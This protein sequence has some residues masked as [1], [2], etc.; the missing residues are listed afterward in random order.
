[1]K[2]SRDGGRTF[3]RTVLVGESDTCRNLNAKPW[4][5]V[6]TNARSPYLGR[7]YLST[8]VFHLDDSGEDVGQ[9]QFV[10]YSDN[11]GK[12]WSN[13]VA[14]SAADGYTHY[15][16]AVVQPDGAL[17]VSYGAFDLDAPLDEQNIVARTSHD[18]GTTF[19][20]SA[21][22]TTNRFGFT[23]NADVRCCMHVL[24]VDP[25]TG[26]L[27]AALGDKR[28]R[29][30]DLNDVLVFRSRGGARWSKPVV[31]ST[32]D[33]GKPYEHFTPSVGAYDGKV[34]VAWT[35]RFATATEL[36]D[37]LRQ[38][39]TLSTDGGR[40]FGRAVNLGPPGDM[41]FAAPAPNGF[42][43][44]FLSD[45]N[46]T[47]AVPGGA[48]TAWPLPLPAASSPHQGLWVASVTP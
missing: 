16:S 11:H 45:Y 6:D 5:V 9:Q 10:Q 7:V 1:M 42:A 8:L 12:T 13:R 25:V 27:Y 44:R 30:D 28:L 26:V 24:S 41:R 32:H 17:T 29:T 34:Y 36:S 40:S 18:G 47:A 48:Y 43:P 39:V 3:G 15:N 35:R 19:D 37:R 14:I 46:T 20:S 21:L 4:V 2:R 23:G 22:I 31:A 33:Q 38:Q